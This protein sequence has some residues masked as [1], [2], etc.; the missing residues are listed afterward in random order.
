[1]TNKLTLFLLLGLLI[2]TASAGFQTVTPPNIQIL[3]Q[4]SSGSFNIYYPGE[5][6]TNTVLSLTSLFMQDVSTK[7]AYY[8]IGEAENNDTICVGNFWQT[9]D[10]AYA[11]L[12][13][14]YM[15]NATPKCF[16]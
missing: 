7:N 4:T 10:Y 9:T 2:S 11:L 14:N 8:S 15:C 5:N 12:Y 3:S 1:M 6:N 13:P 16:V